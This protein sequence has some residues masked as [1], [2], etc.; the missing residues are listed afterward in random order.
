VLTL[1]GF[2][3]FTSRVISGSRSAFWEAGLLLFVL[4]AALF[5]WTIRATRKTPP[6]LAFDTDE[7]S[8]LL[9]HGPYRY[10]RHPFYLS[11]L[12]FWTGTAFATPGLLPWLAPVVMLIVYWNA[13]QREE[14]KFARSRLSNAYRTY[15]AKAGMFFPR[16]RCMLTH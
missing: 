13:A 5:T 10:V 6:T 15:R 2:S 11:Y 14:A 3:W 1:I 8:F 9:N 12:L 7:P 4:S 16:L